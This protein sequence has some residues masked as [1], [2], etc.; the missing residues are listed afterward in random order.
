MLETVND[1]RLPEALKGTILE[2]IM[3]AKVYELI[4][5][6]KAFPAVSIENSLN[7]THSIDFRNR[8]AKGYQKCTSV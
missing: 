7:R 5:A 1:Y 3:R 4:G 2:K 8:N 6:R